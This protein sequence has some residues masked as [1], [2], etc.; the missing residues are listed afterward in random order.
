MA[1]LLC[2]DLEVGP[3]GIVFPFVM[4]YRGQGEKLPSELTDVIH[5]WKEE[6]AFLGGSASTGKGR[7]SLEPLDIFQWDLTDPGS[8]KDYIECSGLR[9]PEEELEEWSEALQGLNPFSLPD[10]SDKYSPQWTKVGYEIKIQSPLLSNDPIA[11][12][13]DTANH[14]AV[15]Y[16]KRVWENGRII[17]RHTFK[18]E[19]IRG[20]LRTALGREYG[21]FELKH[22]D[23]PCSLCTIFGNEHEAGKIRFEDLEIEDG[24]AEKHFDHVAIDRF[25]G[26]AVDKKKFDDFS[27]AGSPGKPIKLKGCFW[28]RA[29]I[30]S[31][32]KKD[33]KKKI[34]NALCDVRDGLYPLGGKGGVG[35][36]WVK[37]LRI[38]DGPDDFKLPEPKCKEIPP[39]GTPSD[40]PFPQLK[41]LQTEKDKVY[42]PHYFLKPAEKKVDRNWEK[43]LIGHERFDKDLLTG[44]I[45]CTLKTLSPLIIPDSEVVT[46]NGNGHKSY[47]FF[48]LN[49]EII[50]PGSE[51]RG[52]I[53]SVY[54]A[55][56]NS[57]FR[58]VD[59]IIPVVISRSV[60]PYQIA[61]KL[62]SPDLRPCEREILE[63]SEIGSLDKCSE[64]RLFRLHEDGLCP[65][66]RLF[67]TTH[68]KGRVRFGFAKHEGGEK[69]LM[70]DKTK[71]EYLTL[72]LLERPRPTWSMPSDE[73]DVPGRKFYVHHNGW[74][75]VKQDSLDNKT[76][77]TE[78]NRSVE[79]LDKDNLFK[80]DVFFENLEPWELGLLLYSLELEEGLAHKFGMAKAFG[81]GS[82]KI[83]ADKILLREAPNEWQDATNRKDDMLRKGFGELTSWFDKD[84]DKVEHIDGLRSLLQIPEALSRAE[85]RYPDLTEDDP[86]KPPGYVQLSDKKEG[87]KYLIRPWQPWYPMLKS[88]TTTESL[89]TRFLSKANFLSAYKR[90]AVK[91]AAGDL[92]NSALNYGY[93]ILY[94]RSI[95]AIIQAGLNPMAGFLHSYQP[96]KPVL[97][98]DLV[99]E[100]R[101]LAVDRGIFTLL[102]RG[103]KIE[104]GRDSLLSAKS[105]KK[106]A[107]S[108][109]GC[110]SSEVCFNGHRLS[111]EDVIKEQALNI[112]KHLYNNAKY[113]P[114]LGRW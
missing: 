96:T 43:R 79:P 2:L 90:I 8:L 64:K 113:R 4:R 3:E 32:E 41:P 77:K 35:Y 25:T 37:E 31:D 44:K 16:K 71:D 49:N 30:F 26:G 60:S 10:T 56:T 23:C 62:P 102:N 34:I 40:Y 47:Q 63:D 53:S 74:E 75:K 55:L 69:W 50:I 57:C 111:L 15:A 108:V 22:E 80:F 73:D 76:S 84:W 103:Q 112:K 48:R 42:S 17:E 67:G 58:V 12:L 68:Y 38:T 5:L 89:L 101:P 104:L 33:E 27:L 94:G 46:E 52:M 45:E 13:F 86:E 54:E 106:I 100:F 14:D 98:Y 83:D 9:R 99:E 114:F 21:L 65:S 85:V 36:G 39:D 109:I 107:K 61:Q 24:V 72:P 92:V 110:L 97:V 7:F 28:L 70:D 81:F 105:R 78:N 19:S 88:I 6:M 82:T 59:D 29:D 11:A 95:N 51:I 18:G 87:R 93:G 20:V 1:K 66:C 91:K